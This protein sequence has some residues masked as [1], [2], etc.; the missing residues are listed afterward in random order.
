ML[1]ILRWV[2][3]SLAVPVAVTAYMVARAF[4]NEAVADVFVVEESEPLKVLTVELL[5][6][7]GPTTL[8]KFVSPLG[9]P[10]PIV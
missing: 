6:F 2:T 5:I 3:M 8:A 7:A 10:P 9:T 1:V 4:T